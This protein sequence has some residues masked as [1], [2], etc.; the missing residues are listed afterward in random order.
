[1]SN[2]PFINPP[3]DNCSP[4]Q[5][6]FNQQVSVAINDL[7]RRGLLVMTGNEVFA[8]YS[9]PTLTVEAVSG[10][11]TYTSI[12]TI[13]FDESDGFA[14]T[15]PAAGIV[16][17][18][19]TT[20]PTLTVKESDGSPSYTSISS[21]EFDQD[22]GFTVSQPG[23]G[24]AKIDFTPQLTVKESDGSPSYTQISSLEF[25]QADGFTLSQPG[26]NRTQVNYGKWFPAELT[27]VQSTTTTPGTGEVDGDKKE[28]SWYERIETSVPGVWKD[29]TASG[30]YNACV[31]ESSGGVGSRAF[32]VRDSGIAGTL[33]MMRLKPGSSTRYEFM[34]PL[35]PKKDSWSV[36]SYGDATSNGDVPRWNSEPILDQLLVRTALTLGLQSTVNA[37]LGFYNQWNTAGFRLAPDSS[38]TDDQS[39][40]LPSTAPAYAAMVLKCGTPAT[41]GVTTYYS[42][43]WNFVDAT[44]ATYT[45]AVTGDWTGADPTT[46]QQ[47]LDRIAAALGPIA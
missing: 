35:P 21:L 27:A 47:A 14:V 19:F 41:V 40:S 3:R 2:L 44:E 12:E 34:S 29:G 5:R 4:E 30:T 18:D 42:T 39:C 17:I 20:P 31:A 1:M 46:V 24:R 26:A 43:E 36:L 16:R 9:D 11:P 23:A 8:L 32:I 6:R 33:V 10:T 37:S 22:D 38:F 45:P 28:Y 25:D 13:R 15:Q 7:I